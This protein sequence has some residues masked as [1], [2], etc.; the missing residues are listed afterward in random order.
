MKKIFTNQGI[1]GKAARKVTDLA[2]AKGIRQAAYD[3]KVGNKVNKKNLAKGVAGLALTV[4]GVAG[5]GRALGRGAVTKA[6]PRVKKALDPFK[7]AQ[8]IKDQR[9][10]DA[11]WNSRKNGRFY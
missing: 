11:L 5:V 10:L 4:G 2:G 8:K 9:Q 6:A 1:I 7:D 3:Y